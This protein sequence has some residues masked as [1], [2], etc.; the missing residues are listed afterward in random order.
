LENHLGGFPKKLPDDIEIRATADLS[1]WI[2]YVPSMHEA[3]IGPEKDVKRFA[4]KTW[5]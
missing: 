5:K 1:L 3:I 2:L 4:R